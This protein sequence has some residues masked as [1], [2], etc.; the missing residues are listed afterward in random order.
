VRR[1]TLTRRR[2][3]ETLGTSF[4]VPATWRP[5]T[6]VYTVR[7]TDNAGN[8]QAKAGRNTLTVR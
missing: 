6:Y 2:V 1:L 3:N 5:G 8:V 7:A 4:R